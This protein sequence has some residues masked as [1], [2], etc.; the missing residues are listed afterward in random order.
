MSQRRYDKE[1]RRIAQSGEIPYPEDYSE[2]MKKLCESLPDDEEGAEGHTKRHWMPMR[3]LRF[4]IVCG[5]LCLI[6]AIVPVSAGIQ[7]YWKRLDHMKDTEK[8]KYVNELM[9][10]EADGDHYSR[11]LTDSENERKQELLI[12]YEAGE[13]YPEEEIT[14]IEKES[15]IQKDKVCFW[16]ET[17]TLF[18]PVRELTD[19]ELLE[20]IDFYHKREYSLQTEEKG[21]E[22]VQPEETFRQT[23]MD[24]EEV[25]KQGRKWI[26]KAFQTD[27][28]G[29]E[30]CTEIERRKSDA[31]GYNIYSVTYYDQETGEEYEISLRAD[32]GEPI[33]MYCIFD[34]DEENWKESLLVE[35]KKKIKKNYKKAERLIITME[36]ANDIEKGYCEY[37]KSKGEKLKNGIERFLMECKDGSG[38]SV[39]YN[40]GYQK[41]VGISRIARMDNYWQNPKVEYGM[42]KTITRIK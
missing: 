40:A 37:V 31:Y 30:W 4:G 41:I 42:K 28:S 21:D 17:S 2:R 7:K 34:G 13:A 29:L 6:M 20:I 16:A 11:P 33:S 8:E 35:S 18:L 22:K 5:L 10:S 32:T 9:E 36:C 39:S 15:Q 26:K 27:T 24:K 25:L 12:S 14:S 19:E 3:G 1:V 38:W 23:D